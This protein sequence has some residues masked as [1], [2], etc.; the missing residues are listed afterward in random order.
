M[1]SYKAEVT[2]NEKDSIQDMLATEK[3]IVKFYALAL[4]EGASKGYRTTLKNN[5]IEAEKDQ[6]QTFL[7][8]TE[9][10]YQSV[11]SES[12]EKTKKEKAKFLKIKKELIKKTS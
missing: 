10:G 7:L 8:L 9:M 12:N 2:L 11:E 4:T 5:F 6:L 1:A 3:E